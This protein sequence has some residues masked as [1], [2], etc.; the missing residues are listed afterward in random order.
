[1]AQALAYAGSAL[2]WNHCI[3]GTVPL[4]PGSKSNGGPGFGLRGD[5]FQPNEK[6]RIFLEKFMKKYDNVD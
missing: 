4:R 3:L 2:I 1:M 6:N 5:P